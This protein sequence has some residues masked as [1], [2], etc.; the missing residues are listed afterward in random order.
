MTDSVESPLSDSPAAVGKPDGGSP[1]RPEELP[2]VQPP[3][4]GYII[5]LF[6]IPALIVVAVIGVWALFGMLA[7]SDTNWQQLVGELDQNKHRR[8]RAALGLAQLLQN[9]K[10][11]PD[12]N[13]LLLAEQPLLAD[14]LTKL[15]RE[16]LASKSTGD[17]EVKQQEFLARTL[18][19]LD[20]DERVLPALSHALSPEWNTEV[21]KSS[22]MALAMIAGRHFEQRAADSGASVIDTGANGEPVYMLNAPLS[23]PTIMDES[24]IQSLKRAAQD[25]E[26]G[27][28]HLTAYV[29]ALISG[30]KAMSEL[31]VMLL[32]GDALT[33]AN[34]AVGLARNGLTDGVPVLIGLVRD[35]S[36]E[37]SREEFQKLTP[38]EQ[39]QAMSARQFEQPIILSN[40]LRAIGSLWDLM[41]SE[42]H[43]ELQPLLASLA[44]T[45]S[46]ADVRLQARSLMSRQKTP[47]P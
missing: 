4:A 2:P 15:L 36:T 9:Q 11:E 27:I 25:E 13:G 39:Q 17:D 7:N 28:R 30:D 18:G 10:T 6:L 19:S 46:A 40:S 29:L 14:A 20:N 34:A 31:K 35:G 5:Q 37:M 24:V 32:D 21:R 45:A 26:A 43:A 42:Q 47:E 22:L 12:E 33:R 23:P 1:I 38:E 3:S 8:W 44:E 16:S 41:S